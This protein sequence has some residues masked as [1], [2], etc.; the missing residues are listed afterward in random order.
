MKHYIYSAVDCG[1]SRGSSVEARLN[2]MHVT[3]LFLQTDPVLHDNLLEQGSG[4]FQT[5]FNKYFYES[6][7]VCG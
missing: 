2:L 4:L 3:Y 1:G 5:L 6:Q 7:E